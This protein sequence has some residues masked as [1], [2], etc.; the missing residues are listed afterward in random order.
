M[1]AD[2]LMPPVPVADLDV[3][4]DDPVAQARA[5][6]YR[7]GRDR[8]ARELAEA[9]AAA[10]ASGA[11]GATVCDALDRAEAAGRSMSD[12]LRNVMRLRH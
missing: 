1:K 9:V 3:A 10:K 2:Y 12:A 7:A 5:A 6:G 8:A 11:D 4:D